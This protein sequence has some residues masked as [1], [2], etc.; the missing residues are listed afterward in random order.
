VPIIPAYAIT[1]YKAQS[2][3]LPN[4]IVDLESC[5]KTQLAYVMVSHAT[6]LDGLLIL[7]PFD[8][9]RVQSHASQEFQD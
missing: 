4:V 2:K 1:D 7:R 3:T 9:K 6:S 8:P 5:H